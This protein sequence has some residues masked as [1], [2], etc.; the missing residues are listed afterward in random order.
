MLQMAVRNIRSIQFGEKNIIKP[1]KIKPRYYGTPVTLHLAEIQIETK[2][3][4]K[5]H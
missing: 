5:Y 1:S 2:H 4:E 3:I